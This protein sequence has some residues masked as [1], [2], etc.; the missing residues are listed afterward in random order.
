MRSASLIA[1]SSAVSVAVAVTAVVGIATESRAHTNF[2]AGKPGDPQKK[3]SLTI[4]IVANE[5]DGKMFYTPNRIE[6]TRGEQI[7]F[8]IRNDG[9]LA[10]ELLLD[11]VAGNAKHKIEMEKNPEMEH[12]DPNGKKMQPGKSAEILWLFDKAGTFEYACLIPGHYDAG[13]RGLVVVTAASSK[14][15]SGK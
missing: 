1:L 5:A 7:R 9:V 10:H 13:M 6:V 15:S 12:D 4:E 8:I 3:T 14:K 2:A 11:S